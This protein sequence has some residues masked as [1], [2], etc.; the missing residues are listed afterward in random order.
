MQARCGLNEDDDVSVDRYFHGLRID[1]Q[2]I[3]TVKIL[4]MLMKSSKMPSRQKILPIIKLES[5]VC[6]NGLYKRLHQSE[7]LIQVLVPQNFFSPSLN[8]RI[9]SHVFIL[10]KRGT[11]I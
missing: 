2:H 10:S 5:L 9:G 1:I 6:P 8:I 11:V 4:I 3:L 7:I